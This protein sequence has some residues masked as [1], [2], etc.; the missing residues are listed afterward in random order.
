MNHSERGVR[1]ARALIAAAFFLS[2]AAALVYQVAWQRILALQS[3]VGI[4]SVAM[5]VSAFMAG[6]GVGS[7]WGGRASARVTPYGALRRFLAIELAIAAFGF[8]SCTVYYD[9]LYTR[10]AWLYAEPWRAGLLHFASLFLPTALMGMSLP[11]LSRAMV[12]ETEGASGTIGVLYGVNLIG[13]GVGAFLTPWVLIRFVGIR[14]AV[15]TAAFANLGA[16]ALAAAAARLLRRRREDADSAPAADP[17]TAG[18]VA[19]PG[20][21]PFALWLALYALSGFCALSLEIV[22]FR[23]VD[24]AVRSKAQ[25]FGTVLAV[26]LLGSAAGCFVA[27]PR[28]RALAHPLRA[29]LL[30]QCTLLL[31]AGVTTA[32]LARL[33]LETWLGARWQAG[34]SASV[35]ATPPLE[36]LAL[37]VGLPAALFG[38]ATFLMGLSFPILQRA[39]QDDPRNSGRTVGILQAANILGC[40]A[41]S[42]LVGLVALDRLGSAG[43]LRLLLVIGLVFAIVGLRAYGL[44]SPFPAAGALLLLLAAMLPSQERL[45]ARL[46]GTDDPQALLGE[47]ATGVGAIVPRNERWTVY[48]DGKSHS[49]LPFGGVHTVLGAVPAIVHPAPV[50]VAVIGLGS[51]DTAWAAGCRAETRSITVFE[52]S[53]PQPRLLTAL[54][55]TADLPDLR[56]FLADPRLL[57]RLGDGRNALTQQDRTYDLI[58]AD[59]LLPDVGYSG[60]LYSTE[61]FRACA[62][63]LKPG[64]VVCTWAPTPRV[65]STFTA[66]FPHVIGADRE[67]GILIGSRDP[68]P[69]TPDVWRTRLEAAEG[70]LRRNRAKQVAS[71]LERLEPWPHEETKDVDEDLFPR[72]EFLTPGR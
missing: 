50:D 11:Y 34:H 63:R 15:H 35:F 31:Y 14:G 2:G 6:L 66:V 65:Y 5:I 57:L 52:I 70:Y 30:C 26:Y 19:E 55:A 41:G 56:S 27:V 17:T 23:L 10:A 21:Q 42:L 4:Y 68:L 9:L 60:N 58:E 51:G 69:I 8:L 46:H 47:D 33:P 49:W 72:D 71:L 18:H 12:T 3:G 53:A 54:A 44:R 16:V 20:R 13:A 32:A 36:L 48:V 62:R 67:R 39:V 22:W 38:P 45:W 1:P 28:V 37:Y 61:F 7:Q 25:T 59:G 64:G 24:V 43:T 29:F 40:T